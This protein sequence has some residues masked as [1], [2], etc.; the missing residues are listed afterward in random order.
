M[1]DVESI[2]LAVI[3][4]VLKRLASLN[5]AQTP[6]KLPGRRMS[7]LK[8][9]MAHEYFQVNPPLPLPAL[10]AGEPDPVDLPGWLYWLDSCPST[11]TWALAQI[12]RLGHGAVV[13]TRQQTAGRG[14]QGRTWYAPKGVLTA[15]FVL[16]QV[17]PD[18]LSGLSLAAGLAVIYAVE[19][20]LPD[21]P[22]A[23][24]LK[25]PN[26]VYAQ[27]RKLAGILCE[28]SFKS[29]SEWLRV[30]VG[31]GLN[32]CVDW[33]QLD[34]STPSFGRPVSLHEVSPQVPEEGVLLER[35]RYYLLQAAG[36]VNQAGLAGLLPALHDRDLL[37]QRALRFQ[38]G[39][40]EIAGL[41]A[42]IDAAGRLLVQLPD[43]SV[44]ALLTGRVIDWEES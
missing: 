30:V 1:L 42:G 33:A 18:R 28:T 12:D 23:L 13:F 21:Q 36:V 34:Q 24:R 41:G 5:L 17:S 39:E 40:Q 26:D 14:Q 29:S 37:R 9:I 8:N 3:Q 7:D 43:G 10:S 6:A 44:R 4:L 16:D 19:D 25:W 27:G 2:Y 11:N 15:S 20:L 38:S 35:L 22:L 31:V 32:R